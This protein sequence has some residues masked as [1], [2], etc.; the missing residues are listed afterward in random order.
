MNFWG[1]IGLKFIQKLCH[2]IQSQIIES[3]DFK[4]LSAPYLR[5]NFREL[6]SCYKSHSVTQLNV[7]VAAWEVE[8]E[9]EERA[10]VP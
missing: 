9:I 3:Y 5:I 7:P 6:K 10:N 1:H 2:K 4:K 8:T